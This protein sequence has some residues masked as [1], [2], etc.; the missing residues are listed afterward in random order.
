MTTGHWQAVYCVAGLLVTG[1]RLLCIVQLNYQSL[2][3]GCCVLCSWTISHWQQAAVYCVAGLMLRC[4]TSSL[5]HQSTDSRLSLT[6]VKLTTFIRSSEVCL[7]VI[8]HLLCH[9]SLSYICVCVS[10]PSLLTAII[11]PSFPIRSFCSCVF[12][13]ETESYV[14]NQPFCLAWARQDSRC[15]LVMSDC[16]LC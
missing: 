7:S 14:M 4:D 15:C 11:S 12:Q 6:G 1:S 16:C 8:S 3:V 10:A 2:V 13:I 9:C 5:H